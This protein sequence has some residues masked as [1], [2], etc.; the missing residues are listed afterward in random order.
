MTFLKE[1][2]EI[3]AWLEEHG[4][5]RYSLVQDD[6]YGYVV[7]VKSSVNLRH[8]ELSY[9]PVKFSKVL[10][11]FDCAYNQLTSLDFCPEEIG[12]YFDC[13]YNKLSSLK[14]CPQEIGGAFTCDHNELNSL[15]GCPESVAN[16]FSCGSNKLTS[17]EGCPK[18]IM[19]NFYCNYN[20]IQNFQFFPD[21][22]TEGIYIQGNDTPI[23][24]STGLFPLFHEEHMK[25]KK[26]MDFKDELSSKIYDGEDIINAKKNKL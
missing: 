21:K 4:I 7:N 19:G 14:G 25:V 26:I 20:N 10:R 5:K 2:K 8:M 18:V 13:S 24:P 15:L 16:T 17:L 22:I 3:I 11:Y 9:I 6:K 1:K 12:T 23:T